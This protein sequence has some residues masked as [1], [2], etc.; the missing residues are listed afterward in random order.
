VITVTGS[1]F[2]L[3]T[4]PDAVYSL[5]QC[6]F[7]VPTGAVPT[8]V[9]FTTN[10]TVLSDTTLTCSTPSAGVAAVLTAEGVN[11]LTAHVTVT[12]NNYGDTEPVLGSNFTLSFA[13]YEMLSGP[14]SVSSYTPSDGCGTG[15]I[16]TV[17]GAGFI[18]LPTLACVFGAN[19][20]RAPSSDDRCTSLTQYQY[21]ACLHLVFC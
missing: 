21:F 2:S 10:A 19:A 7:S 9:D 3:L 13:P 15:D 8:F 4:N 16:I 11:R 17:T 14:L 20:V 12:S 18:N 5:R 6:R 1:G